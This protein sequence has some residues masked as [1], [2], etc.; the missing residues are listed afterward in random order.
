[1]QSRVQ[2]KTVVVYTVTQTAVVSIGRAVAAGKT[3]V[4]CIDFALV[5]F[6]ESLQQF[7]PGS[8]EK[9]FQTMTESSIYA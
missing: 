8:Y 9:L 1:M 6:W 2:T 4:R 7:S 5:K 3:V